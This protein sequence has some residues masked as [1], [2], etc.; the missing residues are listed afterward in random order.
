M[1]YTIQLFSKDGRYRLCITNITYET[2]PNSVY[3]NGTKYT[4]EEMITDKKLYKSNGSPRSVQANYK[5]ATLKEI[6]QIKRSVR[7][8]IKRASNKKNDW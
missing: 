3:P 4:S 6:E 2:Y 8:F 5:R 7:S 1:W